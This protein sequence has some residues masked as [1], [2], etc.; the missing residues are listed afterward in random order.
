[1]ILQAGCRINLPGVLY[2]SCEESANQVKLR[3][4]RLGINAGNLSFLAE[5]DINDI[6]ATIKNTKPSL[7]IIDSIQMLLSRDLASVPGSVTQVREAASKIIELAK[8]LNISVICL[9]MWEIGA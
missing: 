3:L 7:V 5:M 4:N 8:V 9:G 6:V 2:V 1:M